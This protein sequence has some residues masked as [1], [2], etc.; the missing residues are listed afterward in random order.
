MARVKGPLFSMEASG[1]YGGALVFAQRM[2]K[3]V[4]RKLVTPSNPN[5]ASQ[6][7][8]R[9]RVRVFGAIQRFLNQT[10]LVASGQTDTDKTRIGAVCPSGQRWNS[11]IVDQG[12]GSGGVNY[13]AAVAAWDLLDGTAQGAWD[14]AAGAL[15]PA[16]NTVKQTE[17]GGG[18]I[19]PMEAGK[20]WFIAQYTLYLMGLAPVPGATPPTYS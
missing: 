6:E 3:P 14:T 19:T 12:V 8:S 1:A 9:N 15:T 17:A 18:E 4:V 5:A 10:A 2:G 16:I 11:Y 13:T 20:V 7:T